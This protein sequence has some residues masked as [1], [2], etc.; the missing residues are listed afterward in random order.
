MKITN[1][2]SKPIIL[3]H[4]IV[5][6]NI[7]ENIEDTAQPMLPQL[8]RVPVGIDL[9]H[10]PT[11]SDTKIVVGLPELTPCKSEG[12]KIATLKVRTQPQTQQEKIA[13]P[14]IQD[15]PSNNQDGADELH[16]NTFSSSKGTFN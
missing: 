3:N 14:L 5:F 16:S 6:P 8:S 13:D 15:F 2:S 11:N 10:K 9:I 7:F 12:N 1:I 4:Q